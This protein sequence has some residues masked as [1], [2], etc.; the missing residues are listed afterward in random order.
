[1][2][3][4]TLLFLFTV[5]SIHIHA[6]NVG[7]G[8]L[9]PNTKF[10]VLNEGFGIEHTNGTVS[11]KT[12]VFGTKLAQI[13]TFSNH[14]FQLMA[15]NGSGQFILMP[16][17]VVG[18][19]IANSTP[20]L[21]GLVV[22]KSVG[23][24]YGLFGSDTTGVA[25]ESNFP[26]IGFNSYYSSG[27]KFIAEGYGGGIGFNP[28]TGGVTFYS[29]TTSGVAKTAGTFNTIFSLSKDG[30][31]KISGTDAGYIFA[32]RNDAAYGGWNWYA[33]DGKAKL[34][35]YTLGGDI[36]TIDSLGRMGIG[37]TAPS[38][39]LDVAGTTRTQG[40]SS[41]T[42]SGTFAISGNSQNGDAV[43]GAASG[44]GA[45][46]EFTSASGAALVTDLGN[47]GIGTSTPSS[48]LQV[49]GS[50]SLPIK[51]ITAAYTPT[52]SDYTII[53]DLKSDS[54]KN[55]T[56]SLPEASNC[57]GRIYRI[58]GRNIPYVH[59]P[60]STGY[61]IVKPLNS[62]NYFYILHP[63]A[64]NAIFPQ[65]NIRTLNEGNSNITETFTVVQSDG[66]DWNEIEDDETQIYF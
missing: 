19:G 62:S 42:S 33:S 48:R 26:G 27:R 41:S 44:T 46:G 22:D 15:N 29:S 8:T 53:V 4:H 54:T 24:V 49:A 58:V 40:L 14:P 34:Y 61:A 63:N 2:M 20:T 7:I 30:S 9:T 57:T 11:L 39:K 32:D 50:M 3:K 55:I 64:F 1:M 47:A 23:A 52:S 16:N 13:G 28:L 45:G 12:Y 43:Y 37:T 5:I 21:A 36:L 10:S 17:G 31:E 25:I 38:G 60:T 18:I 6:Q 59:Y 56:V 35:R 65:S 66:T 51:V